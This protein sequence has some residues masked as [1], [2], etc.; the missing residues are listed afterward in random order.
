MNGLADIDRFKI[1]IP[2]LPW[3]FLFTCNKD[4]NANIGIFG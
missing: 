1:Y 4:K 2:L 3:I